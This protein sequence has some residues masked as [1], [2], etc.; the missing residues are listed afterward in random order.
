[1]DLQVD[2]SDKLVSLLFRRKGTWWGFPEAGDSLLRGD[3][4]LGD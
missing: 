2:I 1:M 3:T 4:L